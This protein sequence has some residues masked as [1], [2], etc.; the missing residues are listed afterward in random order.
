MTKSYTDYELLGSK[1]ITPDGRRGRVMEVTPDTVTFDDGTSTSRIGIRI[2][3]R[4]LFRSRVTKP[5]Q[6]MTQEELITY[7]TQ[8][9]NGRTDAMQNA[10]DT[11]G[12]KGA[13]RTSSTKSAPKSGTKKKSTAVNTSPTLEDLA[14]FL[15]PEQLEVF[16]K[17]EEEMKRR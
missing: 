1:V 12:I 11:A 8:L 3:E 16:R 17:R 4:Q 9:R 7:L 14:K 6:D 2:I 13:R 15:T 5:I 10:R